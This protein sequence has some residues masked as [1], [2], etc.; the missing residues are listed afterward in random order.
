MSRQAQLPPRGPFQKKPNTHL[1]PEAVPFA[2]PESLKSS[3]QSSILE[4]K[5]AWLDDLLSDPEMNS[6][7]GT[8]L[9]R[10]AS[11]SVTLLNDLMDSFP[12]FSLHDDEENSVESENG[13]GLESACMYGPNSPRK[14]D[15]LI[16]SGNAL[17]SALSESISQDLNPAFHGITNS[18]S[19]VGSRAP[20]YDYAAETKMSKRH[21]GQR[22][23]VRKLQYIA[24]LERTVNNLQALILE[25]DTRARSLLQHRITLS[26]ENSELQHQMAVLQQEK[27]F[28]EGEHQL[29]KKEAEILNYRL[30]NSP[31]NKFRTIFEPSA[32]TQPN[33]LRSA[34]QMPD[35]SKLNLS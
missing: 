35:L 26:V 23:R 11:D 3:L 14:K 2:P 15:H 20:L 10:A 25:L 32:A 13:T 7:G 21:A 29:L 8:G 18:D 19:R 17:V 9:R 31:G 12:P 5:P 30:A 34:W 24:E 33:N 22:S 16:H 27:L 28:V 6:G 4:E 1:S